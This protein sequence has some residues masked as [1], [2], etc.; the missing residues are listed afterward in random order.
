MSGFYRKETNATYNFVAPSIEEDADKKIEVLFPTSVK[1]DAAIDDDY[2]AEIKVVRNITVV[3]LGASA[4]SNATT[5]T[6]TP[7][8][9][10]PIGAVVLIKWVNGATGVDI[11]VK[12]DSSTTVGILVGVGN[13][14]VTK[15]LVWTGTAWLIVG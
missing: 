13:A 9:Q 3:D 15:Q 14:T 8:S 4:L 10:L 5:V 12:K 2:A 7:D 6:L 11:T 1:A